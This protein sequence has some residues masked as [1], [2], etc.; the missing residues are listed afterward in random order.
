VTDHLLDP[1]PG[2]RPWTRLHPLS[3]LLHFGRAI[4]VVAAVFL[5]RMANPLLHE[6]HDVPWPEMVGGAGL[7]LTGFVSWLVTRWRVSHGELQIETGL[8]R[9][10]SIRVP[11]RRVQ[12]IDIVRPLLGRILGLAELRIALA[13]TGSS[14]SRLAYLTEERAHEVRAELLALGAGLA[15]DTPVPSERRIVSV[16]FWTLLASVVCSATAAVV[17]AVVIAVAVAAVLTGSPLLVLGIGWPILLTAGAAMARQLNAEYGFTVAEAPDGL[18]LRSGLLSTRAE[19]VPIGRVQAV[20]W[21]SPVLWRAFGWHR[22]EI[23][24]ARQRLSAGGEH[25]G[26]HLSSALLPVGSE[27]DAATLLARVLPGTHVTPPPGSQPPRRAMWR[28]PLSYRNLRA[29]HDDT[30]VWTRTGRLRPTVTIVPLA[31][32]QSLRW[33]Q[34][35]VQRRLRLATVH[36]DTAG[37]GW[38]AVAYARDQDEAD[39]LL[40]RLTEL[41]RSARRP[42]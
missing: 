30:Y 38:H 2:E 19:T 18:R 23:D 26:G 37:R 27:H 8:I 40:W 1:A 16:D 13:G 11:L 25:E 10:Q 17:T 21:I 15:G 7:V 42:A 32:V 28:A 6:G 33:V 14:S 34:G 12:A 41:S 20:R 35:P 3:P 31:K 9:R 5:P 22:L 29:W 39:L 4:A 36:V 24:V